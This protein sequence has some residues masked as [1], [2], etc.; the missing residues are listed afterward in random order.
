[1]GAR[2]RRRRRRGLAFLYVHQ[3]VVVL[4]RNLVSDVLRLFE[5]RTIGLIGAAGCKYVP[6]SRVW[7][8]GSGVFGHVLELDGRAE[9]PLEFEPVTGEY[10]AVEAVDGLCLI[11][12]HDLPW[13]EDVAPFHFYDVAQATRFVLAG[14]DVVV[15]RQTAPWFAH[16]TTVLDERAR[17][18]FDEARDAYRA[19]TA[20]S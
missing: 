12:Q 17:W 4:N 13:D 9:R 5:T 11:T 6:E 7:W 19:P 3:D 10:E 16:D 15:P 14:Y 1:M 2:V 18:D 20:A 8:D